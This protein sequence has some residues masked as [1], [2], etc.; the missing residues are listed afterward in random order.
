VEGRA[1]MK[2]RMISDENIQ[3]AKD[4]EVALYYIAQEALNNILRHAHARNVSVN[5]RQTRQNVI[6]EIK[7]DGQGFD[8]K[9]LDNSGLGLRNMKERALQANG[10]FRITSKV[11][12][13]TKVVVSVAR[14]VS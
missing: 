6:L 1:D 11:N 8:I 4:S 9:K 13:G 14:K 10:K 12:K 5:I 3:L 7:D 2:A